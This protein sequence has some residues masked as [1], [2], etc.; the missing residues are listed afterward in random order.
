[1]VTLRF[2]LLAAALLGFAGCLFDG[3]ETGVPPLTLAS[4]AET[5]LVGDYDMIDFRLEFTDGQVID[6]SRVKLTGWMRI[7]AD[8]GYI[9]RI[10]MDETSTDTEGRLTGIRA[11]AGN[12]GKGEVTLTLDGIRRTRGKPV[13]AAGRYFGLDYRGRARNGRPVARFQGNRPLPPDCRP[14]A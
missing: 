4:L 7:S 11:Q 13:R 12:R 3:E 1:M 14:I 8:S 5:G 2:L 9:Q 10:W 6:S